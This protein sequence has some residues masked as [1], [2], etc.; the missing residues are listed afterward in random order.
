MAIK[1]SEFSKTRHEIF[2][3]YGILCNLC[4][5]CISSLTHPDGLHPLLYMGWLALSLV[6]QSITL[7]L[8]FTQRPEKVVQGFVKVLPPRHGL[9]HQL[10]ALPG[11]CVESIIPLPQGEGVAWIS[12]KKQETRNLRK[13]KKTQ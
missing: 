7:G 6:L 10:L 13:E 1:Y 3:I 5:L 12:N 2:A 8:Q 9:I 4:M 11:S